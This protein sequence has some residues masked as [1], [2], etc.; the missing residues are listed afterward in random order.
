MKTRKLTRKISFFALC[1]LILLQQQQLLLDVRGMT[2]LLEAS[3]YLLRPTF[4]LIWYVLWNY[5]LQM[6]LTIAMCAGF[7]TVA[8][9][10]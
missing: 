10:V 5:S 8:F 6:T 2:L 7:G 9:A 3:Q 1:N 4:S